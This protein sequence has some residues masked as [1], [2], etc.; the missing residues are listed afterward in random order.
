MSETEE[1]DESPVVR[2]VIETQDAGGDAVEAVAWL[3]QWAQRVA[4][5]APFHVE[6]IHVEVPMHTMVVDV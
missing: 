4:D 3:A 1:H 2:I 5:T 6:H